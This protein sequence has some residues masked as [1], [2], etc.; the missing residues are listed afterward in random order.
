MWI[1]PVTASAGMATMLE[2]TCCRVRLKSRQTTDPTSRTL[3][4]RPLREEPVANEDLD[5]ILVARLQE[6][7]ACSPPLDPVCALA[8]RSYLNIFITRV[9]NIL[10]LLGFLGSRPF[11]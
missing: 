3:F 2:R 5:D 7:G 9:R 6:F 1:D 11:M 10:P 8:L 4:A